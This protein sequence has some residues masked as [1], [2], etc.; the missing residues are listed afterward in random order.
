MSNRFKWIKSE[1]DI[2][3]LRRFEK[4]M[5]DRLH[6][7]SMLNKQLFSLFIE[8]KSTNAP[9]RDE[10]LRR[11]AFKLNSQ[12]ENSIINFKGSRKWINSF[13]RSNNI[14]SRKITKFVT[15]RYSSDKEKIIKNAENFVNE[16]KKCIQENNPDLVINTDQSGFQLELHWSRTLEIC[17]KKTVEGLAQSNCHYT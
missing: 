13:K 17:G 8:K 15:K 9:I 3:M 6:G 4:S 12:M 10:D 16:T 5:K 7:Y 14:V 2:K 11:W 1:N